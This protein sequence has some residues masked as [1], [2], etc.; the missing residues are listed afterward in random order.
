MGSPALK[1]AVSLAHERAEESQA[2]RQ[3]A[4][5]GVARFLA[6][7]ADHGRNRRAPRRRRAWWRRRPKP[8]ESLAAVY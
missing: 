7:R 3:H 6:Y 8:V 1:S 2:L 5:L 4:N